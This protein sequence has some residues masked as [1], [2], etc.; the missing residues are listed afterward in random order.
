[1]CLA[2]S[3]SAFA[4]VKHKS[5]DVWLLLLVTP[6]G[7]ASAGELDMKEFVG[8]LLQLWLMDVTW[9]EPWKNEAKSY[10]ST[11]TTY[12]LWISLGPYCWNWGTKGHQQV[13]H[14]G[15][16]TKAFWRPPDCVHCCPSGSIQ[17]L[18]LCFT[19]GNSGLFAT[20]PGAHH[21][22]PDPVAWYS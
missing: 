6:G 1:M 10:S 5:S 12:H 16:N 4:P 18:H 19:M 8:G 3:F 11:C 14:M 20:L 22:A 7:L 2:P 9:T 15:L 21:H 17:T 13:S